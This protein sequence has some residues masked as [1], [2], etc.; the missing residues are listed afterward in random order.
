MIGPDRGG[1]LPTLADQLWPAPA[2]PVLG[3]GGPGYVVVPA[4]ARPRLVVPAGPGRV[5]AAAVR[6][7]VVP[8]D[9]AARRRQWAVAALFR[10][11]LGRLV[12]RDRLR[13]GDP[14]GVGLDRHLAAVLG[15]PVLASVHIGPARA[16]RKPVLQL[17]RPDGAAAGYA[18]LGVDPLTR[19]LVAAEAGTLAVL[20]GLPLGPVAVPRVLHHGRWREHELLVQSPLPVRLPRASP[21]AARAAE[22]R[23][24]VA[25]AGCRGI[26]AAPL[27]DSPYRRGLA[28]RIAAL[29][30]APERGRLAALLAAAADPDPR[31]PFGAWH[32]DWNGGN[33]AALADGRVLVW[34][35]ERFATGV[36]VGYDAL[37][38]RLQRALSAGVPPRAAAADLLAA[39]P[40]ALLPF[41]PGVPAAAVAL[42]YLVELATRYLA[43][44]Q[45]AAGAAIGDVASWLLPAAEEYAN[46]ER[47]GR[48]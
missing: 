24:M 47:N 48:R 6:A 3:R 18:K 35:W 23:A 5:V 26:A 20:A 12:F 31:V 44:G 16:N 8:A 29:G 37:H 4:A 30:P 2:A 41:G 38:H 27:A 11:G 25:V 21:A 40:A 42:L 34:D 14:A 7:A 45:R 22:L 10:A 32:G 36:P 19:R 1:Y 46:G 9:A 28:D 17:R 43:D 33:S 39:A 15:A 13:P